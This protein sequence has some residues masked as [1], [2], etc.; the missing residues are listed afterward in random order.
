MWGGPPHTDIFDPKPEA[1]NDYCGPL[2]APIA[3]NVRGIR[4]GELMPLL[5]K[6][7]DKYSLIRSMTH[8]EC[9]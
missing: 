5:A 6:Q 7:A 2:N 4:I 9:P 1:G 8:G 3:T